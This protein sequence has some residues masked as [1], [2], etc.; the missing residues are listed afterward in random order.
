MTLEFKVAFSEAATF[1]QFRGHAYSEA[2]S[3][4]GKINLPIIEI[5]PANKTLRFMEEPI[6]TLSDAEAAQSAWHT[7]QLQLFSRDGTTA[8]P[9][10]YSLTYDNRTLAESNHLSC[11]PGPA[12]VIMLS[13]RIFTV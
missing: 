5:N 11:A 4:E 13:G 7:V 3:A 1:F 9:K 6:V 2:D 10:S 12:A 8:N